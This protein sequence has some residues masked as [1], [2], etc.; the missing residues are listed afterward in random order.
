MPNSPVYHFALPKSGKK[1]FELHRSLHLSRYAA[2]W[3]PMVTA[4]R[5]PVSLSVGVPASV[6]AR[7]NDWLL[8]ETKGFLATSLVLGESSGH[9]VSNR[10]SMISSL[11]PCLGP[12]KYEE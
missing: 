8:K 10:N 12:S 2:H 6:V 1:N 5:G 11:G 7:E 4:L 9:P 3:F